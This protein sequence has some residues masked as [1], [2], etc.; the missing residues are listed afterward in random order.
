MKNIFKYMAVAAMS[1]ALVGLTA[2]TDKPEENSENVEST[3]Y[4]F[5]FN[6]ETVSAGATVSYSP[7]LQQMTLDWGSLDFLM[8]NKTDANLETCMKVERTEGPAA[9]DNLSICYGETCKTGT[10]PWTSDVFTLVPGVN[11][12]MKVII[13]FIP[14]AATED[15]VYRITIGKGTS[16]Q[17]PQV[18]YV[19]ISVA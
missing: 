3:S 5:H 15:A 16:L 10:C 13:D 4:A 6:G 19:R 18:M 8:E 11:E 17:D 2:C 12:N 7:T 14:S 1:I 9:F